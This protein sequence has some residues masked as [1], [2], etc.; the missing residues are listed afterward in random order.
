MNMPTDLQLRLARLSTE[1]VQLQRSVHDLMQQCS[2]AS[3]DA[4]PDDIVAKAQYLALESALR[5]P[6]ARVTRA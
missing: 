1:L 2:L 6:E 4:S 5:L 3:D